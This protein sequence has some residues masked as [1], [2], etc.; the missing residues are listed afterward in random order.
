MANKVKTPIEVLKA[1]D[2]RALKGVD[3]HYE[4][5]RLFVKVNTLIGVPTIILAAAVSALAFATVGKA[6]PLWIQMTIGF[7]G[8]LQAILAALHTWL[9]HTEVAEKHRQAGARYAAIRRRIEEIVAF[10]ELIQPSHLQEIRSS[11][12]VIAREAP[13]VPPKVWRLTQLAY[14]GHGTA[15][16]KMLGLEAESADVDIR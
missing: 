2:R 6:S 8:L 13:S 14:N 10:P 9:R 5:S 15:D 11:L 16:G 7:F 1:W 4:S 12:D 3:A